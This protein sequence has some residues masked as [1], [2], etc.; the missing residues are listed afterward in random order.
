MKRV[1]SLRT[2]LHLLDLD[3][4]E[5][6]KAYLLRYGGPGT[7]VKGRRHPLSHTRRCLVHPNYTKVDEGR[8]FLAFLFGLSVNFITE[9]Y[10]AM[11]EQACTRQSACVRM[12]AC[13]HPACLAI[14]FSYPPLPSRCRPSMAKSY[15]VPGRHVMVNSLCALPR[16]TPVVYNRAPPARIWTSWKRT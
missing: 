10:A 6:L 11:R 7:S 16:Q 1:Y 8:R 3:D 12:F 5:E 15:S 14:L 2:A 4:A 13:I 9:C